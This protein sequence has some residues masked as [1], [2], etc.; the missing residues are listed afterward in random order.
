MKSVQFKSIKRGDYFYIDENGTGWILDGSK[1]RIPTRLWDGT[2]YPLPKTTIVF[3]CSRE[4]AIE[5]TQNFR[6]VVC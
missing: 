5:L 6:K 2:Y 4:Q 1:G 3:R